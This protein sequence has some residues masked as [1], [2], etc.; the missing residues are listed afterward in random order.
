MAGRAPLRGLVYTARN[1]YSGAESMSNEKLTA[2]LKG[3]MHAT[4]AAMAG[5]WQGVTR[6]W[7]GPDQLA[8][9]APIRGTLRSVLGGR[10]LLHEYECTFDGRPESGMALYGYHIDEA[11]F[12]AAWIDDFHTG[13][14]IQYAAGQGGHF[15]VL[16]SYFAGAGEPRWGWRTEITQPADDRLLI[17]M[18]NIPPGGEAVKAVEFD[19]RR[20]I[21]RTTV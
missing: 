8:N 2:S 17:A 9:E 21:G 6:T 18:Y 3:G 14:A 4:F 12:E 19:Y 20:I 1:A 13:T 10:F 16:G 15:N 7:F 5:A 11:Q